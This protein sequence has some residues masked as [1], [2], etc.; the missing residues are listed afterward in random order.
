MYGPRDEEVI[1]HNMVVFSNQFKHLKFTHYEGCF[2]SLVP[3]EPWQ[4]EIMLEIAPH[5]R[6]PF[7]H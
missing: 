4:P 7:F 3:P 5:G 6:I 1:Y 2:E